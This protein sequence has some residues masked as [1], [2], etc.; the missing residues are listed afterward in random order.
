MAAQTPQTRER[1]GFLSC[2]REL[3]DQIY[4]YATQQDD[5]LVIKDAGHIFYGRYVI[6]RVSSVR[7]TESI[8]IQSLL[9]CSTQVG[10]EVLDLVLKTNTLELRNNYQLES[11]TLK[12]HKNNTK[13]IKYRVAA[14]IG[15]LGGDTSTSIRSL[16]LVVHQLN[17]AAISWMVTHGVRALK[18]VFESL[19]TVEVSVI[20]KDDIVILD[21]L[22]DFMKGDGLTLP[23]TTVRQAPEK[24][25]ISTMFKEAACRMWP[26][27]DIKQV[28]VDLFSTQAMLT[29]SAPGM[30]P[31][32]E[33]QVLDQIPT[34]R[35]DG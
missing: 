27:S 32:I 2:P 28:C 7:A 15:S 4:K 5:T 3:R 11:K 8:T 13:I 25:I 34:R 29:P 9:K 26:V 20:D 16:S 31:R 19:K 14:A 1:I 22:V 33:D 35:W 30:A 10:H 23:W 24:E 18:I 21:K 17:G 6:D 12:I